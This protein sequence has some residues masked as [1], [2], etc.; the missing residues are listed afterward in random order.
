ML[1]P[2]N[3]VNHKF[4]HRDQNRKGSPL[5]LV[6]AILIER[7]KKK[8]IWAISQ[9]MHHN[10]LILLL[11]F[12]F[13]EIKKVCNYL[14]PMVKSW[15]P[16]IMNYKQAIETQCLKILL[17]VFLFNSIKKVT[18][19]LLLLCHNIIETWIIKVIDEIGQSLHVLRSYF[20]VQ[21]GTQDIN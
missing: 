20:K 11:L 15:N 2:S 19:H 14:I 5:E 3:Q 13:K 8:W 10:Q 1:S 9:T 12:V 4:N 7:M 18:C 16:L 17:Q 6:L 21:V